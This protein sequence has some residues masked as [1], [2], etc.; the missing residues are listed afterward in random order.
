MSLCLQCDD[1]PGKRKKMFSV[2]LYVDVH[3][4]DLSDYVV[5]LYD[6]GL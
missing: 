6:L 1:H 4:S 5:L 2:C 3:I